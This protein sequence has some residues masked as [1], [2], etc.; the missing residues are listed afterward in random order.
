MAKLTDYVAGFGAD[1]Y[2]LPR[3][4]RT[5][6]LERKEWT[7]P[8]EVHGVVPLMAGKKLRYRVIGAE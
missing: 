4:Q 1:F 7:V 5:L 2:R 8:T 3:T 6:L